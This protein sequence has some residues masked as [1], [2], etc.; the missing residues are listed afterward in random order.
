[1]N[2]WDGDLRTIT[3]IAELVDLTLAGSSDPVYEAGRVEYRSTADGRKEKDMSEDTQ[4]AT[5]PVKE[6]KQTE[7]HVE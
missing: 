5:E 2:R 6:Q 7:E 3:E 1:V 4:P